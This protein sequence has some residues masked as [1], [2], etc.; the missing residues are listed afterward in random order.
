PTTA[1]GCPTRSAGSWPCAPRS[2]SA[3]RRPSTTGRSSTP[4]VRER[5]VCRLAGRTGDRRELLEQSSAPLLA[6][7]PPVDRQ[8]LLGL[9]EDLGILDA[10]DHLERG[11]GIARR[12]L[13]GEPGGAG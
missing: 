4:S 6:E 2:S 12:E 13:V 8:H 3:A 10:S 7:A 9:R 1:A 11:V 5:S